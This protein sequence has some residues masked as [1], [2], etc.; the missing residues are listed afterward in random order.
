MR[1]R[2]RK[3]NLAYTGSAIL[4]TDA[5]DRSLRLCA[6]FRAGDKPTRPGRAGFVKRLAIAGR[7]SDPPVQFSGIPAPA[8]IQAYLIGL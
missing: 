7:V 3:A 2:L 1:N 4:S 5:T 6:I 8:G